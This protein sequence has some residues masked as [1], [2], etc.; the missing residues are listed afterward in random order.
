MQLKLLTTALLSLAANLARAGPSPLPTPAPLPVIGGDYVSPF[1]YN[2]VNGLV[3]A[4][5]YEALREM[6]SSFWNNPTA[7]EYGVCETSQASLPSNEAHGAIYLLNTRNTCCQWNAVHTQCSN[8]T[9]RGGASVGFCGVYEAC[10]RCSPFAKDR[11]F[12][13]AFYCARQGANRVYRSGGKW[14]L[15]GAGPGARLILYLTR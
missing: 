3:A 15:D 6:Y 9:S 13:V 11:M 4:G 14:M 1:G 12:A 10:L 7:A 5:D 8:L 2:A